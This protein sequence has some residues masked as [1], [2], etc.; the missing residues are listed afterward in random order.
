[1]DGG[2]EIV[3]ANWC[4][5]KHIICNVNNYIPVKIPSHPYVLVNRSV[6]CNCGIEADNHYLLESLATCDNRAHNLVMYFTINMAFTNYL[7][8]LPNLTIP[9]LIRDRTIYELPLPINL[10]FPVFDSSL[11]DAPTNLKSFMCS[12]ALNKEIFDFKQR[13]VSTVESSNNSNKNYFSNNYIVDIFIFTSSIISLIS[14]TLVIYLFCKHKHIRTPVASLVLHKIKE[15][16]ANPNSE[17]TDSGCG[18]LTYVGIILT[19]LNMIIVIFLHYRKSRLCKGY[20][21]LNAVKIMLFISDVQHYVPI[22]LCKTAGSIHL[23]KIKGALKSGY[24]KLNKNYLWYTL[25]INWNG[26][27]VT[28]NNDKIELP[29]IVAIKIQEK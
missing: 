11:Q 17:Q 13:H 3:L 6:L 24:I 26:V 28:F 20:R 12:Y 10:T 25:E 14:T 9:A 7:N 5:D 22:K 1:M 27:T 29:K 2:D 21:F 4:N 15:V 19:V 23:F 16:K 8:M 18:T